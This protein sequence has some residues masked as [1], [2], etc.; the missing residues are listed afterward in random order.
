MTVTISNPTWR[1]GPLLIVPLK[2]IEYGDDVGIMEK[3][4][5]T[6]I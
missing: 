3:K 5:E 4:M 1:L 2:K 6:T